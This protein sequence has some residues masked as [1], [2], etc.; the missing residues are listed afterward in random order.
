MYVCILRPPQ[1]YPSKILIGAGVKEQ[2][3]AAA[4]RYNGGLVL[5]YRI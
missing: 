1:P 4:A 5:S 3:C 2:K